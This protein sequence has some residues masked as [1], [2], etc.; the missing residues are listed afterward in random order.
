MI[1]SLETHAE[2]ARKQY[3]GSDS[4]YKLPFLTGIGLDRPYNLLLIP[5]DCRCTWAPFRG[6]YAL[7]FTS[8]LCLYHGRLLNA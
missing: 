8:A 2:R 4:A 5:V 7:K 3:G 6:R 1:N